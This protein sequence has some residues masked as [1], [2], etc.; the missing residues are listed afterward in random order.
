M[1]DLRRQLF[2]HVQTLS[3]SFHEKFTSGRVISRLTSDIDTLN[4]LLSSAMDGL[5]TAVLNIVTISVI[6][7]LLDLPLAAIA[8]I[9]FVPLWFLTSWF[10]RGRPRCSAVPGRP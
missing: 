2:D 8:L 1:F 7:L 10:R 3:L 9:S 4:E 6:L 5:V